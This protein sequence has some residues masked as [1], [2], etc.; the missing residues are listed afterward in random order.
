MAT[1]QDIRSDI[2]EGRYFRAGRL[3]DRAGRRPHELARGE[4]LGQ[5]KLFACRFAVKNGREDL[6]L[7]RVRVVR[8][9][10]PAAANRSRKYGKPDRTTRAPRECSP[11]GRWQIRGRGPQ[12]IRND[13]HERR[14]FL[15]SA[16]AACLK[17]IGVLSANPPRCASCSASAQ[18]QQQQAIRNGLGPLGPITQAGGPVVFAQR[19]G[20]R[21]GLSSPAMPGTDAHHDEAMKAARC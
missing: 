6:K 2:Q 17:P 16:P 3:P 1:A 15:A 9:L 14:Y 12:D 7:T 10:C 5:P 13:I 8:R 11:R 19:A 21:A 18:R 4:F 20:N